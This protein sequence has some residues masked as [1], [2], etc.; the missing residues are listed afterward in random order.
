[1]TPST[2]DPDGIALPPPDDVGGQRTVAEEAVLYLRRLVFDGVLRQGDRVPQDDIAAALGISRIPVREALLTLKHEGWVTVRPRRGTFI[3]AID[4]SIVRDHY[5]LYGLLYGFAARR[6][7]ARQTPEI[8]ARLVDQRRE[9]LADPRPYAV[10]RHN[11]QFHTTIV[12][13]ARSPRLA[14][15]LRAMSGIIPGN[16]FEL[17]PGSI[18]VELVGT[19]AILRCVERQDGEGAAAAYADMMGRQGD[20]VV[21]LFERRG[22][23][24]HG[25]DA[26]AV[27]AAG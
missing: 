12:E 10:W 23:F 16:F 9:L 18:D 21:E 22:L 13:L 1:M 6:A 7:A 26:P 5:E 8:I 17:V 25:D 19:A 11:R 14:P 27:A 20:L 24:G 4:E 15:L 2:R 3:A